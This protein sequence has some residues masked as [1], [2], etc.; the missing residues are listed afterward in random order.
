MEADPVATIMISTLKG[1]IMN[2]DLYEP[3]HLERAINHLI[4]Y[5]KN[6]LQR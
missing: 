3:I 1:A 4:D 2:S 5:I 6:K